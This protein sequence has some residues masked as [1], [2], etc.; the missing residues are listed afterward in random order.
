[1]QPRGA[2]CTTRWSGGSRC[3]R[4][5]SFVADAYALFGGRNPYHTV[6]MA[7]VF[8]SGYCAVGPSVGS[9]LLSP[10]GGWSRFNYL[11][12]KREKA[13]SSI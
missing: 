2:G 9:T 3:A 10:A 4:R 8:S 7:V 13:D 1:M 11:L 6:W 12:L 5:F